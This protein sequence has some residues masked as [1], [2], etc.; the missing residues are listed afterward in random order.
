MSYTKQNFLSGQ[1][2]THDNL[3]RMENGI[4]AAGNAANLLDNS[5]FADPVNQRG[6]SSYSSVAYTIDRWFLNAG[7][8]KVVSGGITLTGA[9]DLASSAVQR[10]AKLEDGV[11]TFAAN[12]DGEVVVL[13]VN[14]SGES[15]TNVN[16]SNCSYAGGYLSAGYSTGYKTYNFLIRAE[17]GYT[18][19]F[20]WTA[21]YKG[22]YTKDTLPD[23]VPKGYAKEFAECRRYFASPVGRFTP[24]A[25]TSASNARMCLMMEAPMRVVPTATLLNKDNILL[26]ISGSGKTLGVTAASTYSMEGSLVYVDLTCSGGASSNLYATG[27]TFLTSI[28]L[29][30][31]T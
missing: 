14:V 16:N 22:E 7:T 13:V 5:N 12:V 31:D 26:N 10:V 29:S 18:K 19:T 8:L 6:N 11:Y 3:N 21:L 2:V 28:A 1:V 17:I 27:T 24:V 23:Y 15:M 9:S 25:M 30:A 20:R 4:V